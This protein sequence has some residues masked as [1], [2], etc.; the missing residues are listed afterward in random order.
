MFLLDT[1]HVT[2]LLR[3][4]P[5]GLRIQGRMLSLTAREVG[6]TI[7]TYEEQS[8]GWLSVIS[9]AKSAA[10]QIEAYGR[11]EK[12]LDY[13]RRITVHGFSAPA[14]VEFQRLRKTVRVGTMD[15]RIAAVALALDATV[16]SCNR[17][18]FEKVPGLRME[19]WSK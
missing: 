4:S 6:T 5:E 12:H 14:A 15:L 18:D 11:L 13:F 17:R 1:D 8:R 7:I 10:E 16:V 9:R 19:D 3:G 2:F